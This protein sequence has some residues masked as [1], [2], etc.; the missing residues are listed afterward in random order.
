[1]RFLGLVIFLISCFGFSQNIKNLDKI[2]INQTNQ[3]QLK[4]IPLDQNKI[5]AI[6]DYLNYVDYV[7][8]IYQLL[9]IE[10]ISA[11]DLKTSSPN[12]LYHFNLQ[13]SLYHSIT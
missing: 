3:N 9:D 5:N 10:E 6:I 13:F 11:S 12:Y 2:N 1:M 7:K 4:L 8:N